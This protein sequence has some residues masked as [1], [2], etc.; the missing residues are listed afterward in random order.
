VNPINKV[1]GIDSTY[2]VCDDAYSM[3]VFVCVNK[4]GITEVF[5]V[6]AICFHSE[7]KTENFSFSLESYTL[8]GFV[9]PAV[10]F[11]DRSKALVAAIR[12]VWVKS[13]SGLKHFLCIYHIYRNIQEYIGNIKFKK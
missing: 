2:K 5:E 4:Y 3:T 6:L 7:E 13:Y 12:D 8:A 1:I 10:V 11:T 9:P